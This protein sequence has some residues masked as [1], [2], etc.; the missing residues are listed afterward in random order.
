MHHQR[1]CREFS[2]E[3]TKIK[4]LRNFIDFFISAD[5]PT[6]F[7]GPR[8]ITTSTAHDERYRRSSVIVVQYR[9]E[10]RCIGSRVMSY[11]EQWI[12]VKRAGSTHSTL[13]NHDAL[14]NHW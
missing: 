10:E 9:N 1:I 5:G 8:V 4:D 3:K 12:L 14:V 6:S 2:N 7:S 13:V 11:Y